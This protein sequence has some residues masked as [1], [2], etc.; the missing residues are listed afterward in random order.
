VRLAQRR[1]HDHFGHL[2]ADQ[3]I[4]PVPEDALGG[5]VG[6]GDAS[7]LVDAEDAVMRRLQDRSQ[8]GLAGGQFRRASLGDLP[9]APPA[10][11]PGAVRSVIAT[12]SPY[13][14]GVVIGIAV[15]VTGIIEPSL[16]THQSSSR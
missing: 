3:L 14:S 4:G 5:G 15:Q 1:R 12:A 16:R 11:R 7:V 6:V 9:L 2:L 10:R 13:P 8:A